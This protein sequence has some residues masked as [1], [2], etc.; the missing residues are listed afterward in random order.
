MSAR[1]SI[2]L[3]V[4]TTSVIAAATAVMR[5][6]ADGSKPLPST[7]KEHAEALDDL[8]KRLWGAHFGISAEPVRRRV[9]G[10]HAA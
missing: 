10:E 9:V 4:E 1:I 3:A 8:S 7:I 2:D 6:V 5:M